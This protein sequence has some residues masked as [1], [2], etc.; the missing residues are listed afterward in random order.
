MKRHTCDKYQAQFGG[1]D[2]GN[3]THVTAVQL[4][5]GC[6][7]SKGTKTPFAGSTLPHDGS[8]DDVMA[9]SRTV[10]VAETAASFRRGVDTALGNAG[11]LPVA[12]EDSPDAVL[13]TLRFPEG[14]ETV[15]KLVASGAVVVALLPDPTP[16]AHAHAYEHGAAGTVD[17][18]ADPE[19][20]VASLHTALEGRTR[21]PIEVT[22][23]LASEWPSLHAPRPEIDEDEVDWLVALASGTT[24]ARLADDT[25][26]SERA[27]F[28]K[29]HDVYD[30]LGVTSRAEAIVAAERLGLLDEE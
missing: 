4:D 26:Y 22:R 9:A 3:H 7:G 28:R 24:V 27:L 21:L 5:R 6:P 8:V 19:E 1:P 15:T 25:G 29:L 23:V 20:I 18:N 17:W 13:A 11:Y 10:A 16:E 30:R 14:C 2:P 12:I